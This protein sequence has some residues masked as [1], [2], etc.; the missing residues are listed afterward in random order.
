M[1]VSVLA[2]LFAMSASAG[3]SVRGR[4]IR[5]W[6]N[7]EQVE[8]LDADLSAPRPSGKSSPLALPGMGK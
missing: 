5:F 1:K 3:V 8:V 6:I 2:L 7:R 4:K